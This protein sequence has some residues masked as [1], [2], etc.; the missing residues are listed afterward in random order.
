M[1]IPTIPAQLD[2]LLN[3]EF[4]PQKA[5]S[6]SVDNWKTW[7]SHLEGVDPVLDQLPKALNRET[8]LETVEQLLPENP[9]AAFTA[10]MIWGHGT[11]GYGPYRTACV[12]TADRK[13]KNKQLSEQV[14]ERLSTSVETARNEGAV[15]GYRYLNNAE[16]K[17]K[18]LGPAFFTK[19]LYF[20]TGRGN[21]QSIEAAPILDILIIRWLRIHNVLSLRTGITTD[22]EQ[23]VNVLTSWG[24]PHGLGAA[25]VEEAIF[26]LIRDDG[27]KSIDS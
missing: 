13:P 26:R 9:A 1:T 15:E 23:Y 2:S 6:Y 21:S 3:T 25:R 14:I 17:I 7:V 24:T 5:F 16:G 22:Y 19:W 12:L 8:V 18:G 11:S 10:A 27:K 20:V 4:E